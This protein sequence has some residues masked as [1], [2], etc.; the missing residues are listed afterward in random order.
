MRCATNLSG[1]Y[2]CRW[3]GF[4]PVSSVDGT[5]VAR[6]GGEGRGGPRYA[7]TLSC[8]RGLLL[9]ADASCLPSR[10]RSRGADVQNRGRFDEPI[11]EVAGLG[12]LDRVDRCE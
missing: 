8:F 7:T 10:K 2:S 12:T 9:R 11:V 4:L 3:E 5:R 6:S 1:E